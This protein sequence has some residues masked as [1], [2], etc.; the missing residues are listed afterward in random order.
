M[1]AKNMRK[2]SKEDGQSLFDAMFT[3]TEHIS[4]L[5]LAASGLMRTEAFSLTSWISNALLADNSD[6]KWRLGNYMGGGAYGR[7]FSA[8]RNSPNEPEIGDHKEKDDDS[9]NTGVIKLVML[10]MKDWLPPPY[11]VILARQFYEA[12]IGFRTYGNFHGLQNTDHI[13]EKEYFDLLK[14]PQLSNIDSLKALHSIYGWFA[15]EAFAH[16]LK[17]FLTLHAG[18]DQTLTTLGNAITAHMQKASAAKLVHGD[19]TLYNVGIQHYVE[20]GTG[21]KRPMKSRVRLL[22]YGR[23]FGR[24]Q[25]SKAAAA[26]RLKHFTVDTA[27]ELGNLSDIVTVTG[28]LMEYGQQ[29]NKPSILQMACSIIRD[30]DLLARCRALSRNEAIPRRGRLPEDLRKLSDDLEGF[31][32]SAMSQDVDI[33]TEFTK[34]TEDTPR[35]QCQNLYSHASKIAH[36]I[37]GNAPTFYEDVV[38]SNIPPYSIVLPARTPNRDS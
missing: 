31:L 27:C 1:W 19:L 17:E 16:T 26:N 24:E 20:Q 11:E 21:K 36:Y 33:V 29:I 37:Y 32:N 4:Q 28:K 22:D 10:S 15:L 14:G 8:I 38:G 35:G 7:V 13:S 3:H 18:D 6:F 12:D 23:S 9:Q 30:T 5:E 2:A 34:E 25:A